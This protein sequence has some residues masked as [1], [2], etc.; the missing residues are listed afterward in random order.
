MLYYILATIVAIVL[1]MLSCLLI[2]LF[3][4]IDQQNEYIEDMLAKIEIIT[5]DYFNN[6]S[7]LYNNRR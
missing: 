1:I 6:H 2:Y 7:I 4:K 3:Y 5:T